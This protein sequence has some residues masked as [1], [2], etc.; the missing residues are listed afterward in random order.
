VVTI[1]GVQRRELSKNEEYNIIYLICYWDIDWAKL[2]G[3]Y[4]FYFYYISMF[5]KS[6]AQKRKTIPQPSPGDTC[7]GVKMLSQG[8]IQDSF[9][10]DPAYGRNLN[11]WPYQPTPLRDIRL[12]DVCLCARNFPCL[13][14]VN[15]QECEVTNNS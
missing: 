9:S 8:V 7:L 14:A 13:A 4:L 12:P 10:K 2:S 11:N 1:S 5:A 6:S 15:Q 3:I